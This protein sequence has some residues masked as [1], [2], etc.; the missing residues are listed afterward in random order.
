MPDWILLCQAA[1]R[2]G[3]LPARKLICAQSSRG[4]VASDSGQI[5]ADP[6]PV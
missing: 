2:A 1:A 5:A 6:G 4:R 3:F